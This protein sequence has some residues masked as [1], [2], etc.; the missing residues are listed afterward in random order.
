ME[1][2]AGCPPGT[3]R[4]ASVIS[5]AGLYVQ[6]D[7]RPLKCLIKC[8]FNP[9]KAFLQHTLALCSLSFKVVGVYDVPWTSPQKNNF[10]DFIIL[11]LVKLM[12]ELQ[13]QRWKGF[14]GEGGVFLFAVS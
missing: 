6:I 10:L 1:W 9:R 2:L 11:S 13:E 7:E 4:I 8:L 12:F 5:P 3:V 14:W